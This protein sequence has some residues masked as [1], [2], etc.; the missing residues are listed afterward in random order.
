MGIEGVLRSEDITGLAMTMMRQQERQD[1][2]VGDGSFPE[3]EGKE[4]GGCQ[5]LGGVEDKELII[6]PYY[7]ANTSR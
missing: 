1:L 2:E 4:K 3:F 5:K 7:L 6:W